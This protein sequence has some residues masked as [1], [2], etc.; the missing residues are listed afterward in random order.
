M[1]ERRTGACHAE[2]LWSRPLLAVAQA[3]VPSDDWD[4]ACVLLPGILPVPAVAQ[5]LVPSDDWDLA[6]VLLPG[7]CHAEWLWFRPSRAR[8]YSRLSGLLKLG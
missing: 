3:L 8:K 1:K 4:L 2:W 5:A 7:A 6:C